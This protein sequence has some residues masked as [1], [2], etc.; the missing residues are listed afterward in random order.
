MSKLTEIERAVLS[1]ILPDGSLKTDAKEFIAE[2]QPHL[3]GARLILGG[4]LAKGTNLK[5]NHDCDIFIA[6]SYDK[7]RTANISDIAQGFL[8]KAKLDFERIHGS[9]DYFQIQ[10]DGMIYELVPVL[11]IKDSSYAKNVTDMSPLHVSW[12]KQHLEKQPELGN[13]IRLA[14]QF[15]KAARAY[16]AESYIGG[17]SGHV[18]DI[19]VI[20]YGGF[21]KLLEASQFWK[22]RDVIDVEKY[23]DGKDP[24]SVLNPSKIDSPL[25]VIDPILE[26]R[27]AASALTPEKFELFIAHAKLYLA[28]PAEDCFSIT[29]L[30]AESFSQPV[31]T[32]SVVPL[33]DKGDVAGAKCKKA[34]EFIVQKG[35]EA[36]FIFDIADWEYGEK[37]TVFFFAVKNPELS[38]TQLCMGPPSSMADSVS[39]FK[40]E[41]AGAYEKDGRWYAEEK[42]DVVFFD[43]FLDH[44]MQ[45]EHVTTR[46]RSIERA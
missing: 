19:L 38:P 7:H 26:D 30:T 31:I 42:R 45:D 5:N 36:D 6:F 43:K 34:F 8:E 25:I 17:F 23:Y 14:K 9:R 35:K 10:R 18:I 27:N 28:G 40:R 15:C 24:L 33:A 3:S 2:L 13:Q 12:V 21:Q 29:K 39:A 41:H 11:D 16:G 44:V 32:L 46:V 37:Q 22:L 20:H 4:S 1:R